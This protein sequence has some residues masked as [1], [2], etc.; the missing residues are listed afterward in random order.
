MATKIVEKDGKRGILITP[1]EGES[2][3]APG[4]IVYWPDGSCQANSITICLAPGN[5]IEI[6]G[7][8]LIARILSSLNELCDRQK[9]KT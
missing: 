1:K 9:I 4:A 6:N 5:F 3:N 2:E 8:S 7:R